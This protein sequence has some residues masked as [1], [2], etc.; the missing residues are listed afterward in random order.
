MTEVYTI[1]SQPFYDNIHKCYKHIYLM[2]RMPSA[3]L[4]SIVRNLNCPK[5]SPFKESTMCSPI[6]TCVPAIYNPNDKS[7]L[8]EIGEEAILFTYL[9]QNAY[10]VDTSLTK[11]MH[12]NSN[13][14]H[15]KLLC[16]ISKA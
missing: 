8:L 16:L 10:T 1:S 7:K 5:F 13:K 9:I 11:I 12:K 15:T 6:P 3:P 14:S 4:S 2:D